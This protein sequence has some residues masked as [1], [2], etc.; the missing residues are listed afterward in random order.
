MSLS[1]DHFVPRATRYLLLAAFLHLQ[2]ACCCASHSAGDSHDTAIFRSVCGSSE[3]SHPPGDCGH[4]HHD[5]EP[6]DSQQ[7]HCHFCVLT[8]L[9]FVAGSHAFTFDFDAAT[10]I[11]WRLDDLLAPSQDGSVFVTSASSPPTGESLLACG[12]MLRI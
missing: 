12:A 10:L 4:E 6:S 5:H 2:V 3:H 7:D 11:W 1:G 9:Q 8:H